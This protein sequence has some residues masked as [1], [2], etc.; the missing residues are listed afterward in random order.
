MGDI[1]LEQVATIEV[2]YWDVEEALVLGIV[3]V[4]SDDVIRASAGQKV[5]DQST[6]LR[7]PLLVSTL[8]SEFRWHAVCASAIDAL[9]WIA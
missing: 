4:H 6:G 1:A 8:R 3:K 7:N 5:R 2:V 9:F